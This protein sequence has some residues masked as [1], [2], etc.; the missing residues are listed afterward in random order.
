VSNLARHFPKVAKAAR[1][2]GAC[3][4]AGRGLIFFQV[5]ERFPGRLY[6]A[7]LEEGH[8]GVVAKQLKSVAVDF[9]F[10]RERQGVIYLTPLLSFRLVCLDFLEPT[11]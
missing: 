9:L 4:R 7:A 8:E 1:D 11:G 2:F 6:T 5:A 3:C 10:I